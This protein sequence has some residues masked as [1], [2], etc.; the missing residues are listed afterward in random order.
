M[1]SAAR[2]NKMTYLR[3]SWDKLSAFIWAKAFLL[4]PIDVSSA[5]E[6]FGRVAP[7]FYANSLTYALEFS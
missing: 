7:V 1:S 5:I 2:P 3:S 4:N 6:S